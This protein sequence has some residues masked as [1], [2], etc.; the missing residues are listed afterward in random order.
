MRLD[1]KLFQSQLPQYAAFYTEYGCN[2]VAYVAHSY[3]ATFL[4]TLQ[5]AGTCKPLS[6]L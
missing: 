3:I 2:P 1:V 5:K 4:R 6:Q